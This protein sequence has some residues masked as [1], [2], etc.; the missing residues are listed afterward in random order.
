MKIQNYT[1]CSR[2]YSDRSLLIITNDRLYRHGML[3]A[4]LCHCPTRNM[5]EINKCLKNHNICMH[6]DIY[7]KHQHFIIVVQW[8]AEE[9]KLQAPSKVA[10]SLFFAR[11][12]KQPYHS[13]LHPTRCKWSCPKG[14]WQKFNTRSTEVQKAPLW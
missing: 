4:L 10:I 5:S 8:R 13:L 3:V 7:G 2:Q 9:L 12:A 1:F 11:E 6:L 14:K